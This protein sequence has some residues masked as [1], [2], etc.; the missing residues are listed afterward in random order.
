M[1][2]AELVIVCMNSTAGTAKFE[3]NL[4]REKGVKAGVLKIRMF[5]PF[6]A[7]EIAKALSKAKAVAVL[8]KADG[9][10][11]SGGPLFTEITSAMQVNKVNV[12]TISY[13]YGIGGRDTKSDDIEKVY[14]DLQEIVNTN[15]IKNPYRYLGLRK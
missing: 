15:D 10:S 2:D 4:L 9:L 7:E 13:I 6:P 1:E 5:R 11:T 3:A 8:D 14:N 12:P